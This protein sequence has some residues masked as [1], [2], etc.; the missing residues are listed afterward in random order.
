MSDG[1]NHERA[2]EAIG[3]LSGVKS[4]DF[5]IALIV[6]KKVFGL[7]ANLSNVLQSESLDLG[8]ASLLIQSTIDTFNGLRSDQQWDLLWEEAVAFAKHHDIEVNTGTRNNRR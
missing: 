8:S 4:F 5:V 1:S 2:I 3:I 7:S 6:F